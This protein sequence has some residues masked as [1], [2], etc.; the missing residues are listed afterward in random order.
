M[1]RNSL[2]PRLLP[3]GACPAYQY[4]FNASDERSQSVRTHCEELWTD[5][6]CYADENFCSEFPRRFHQRWFEMYLA[7]SLI[8]A[9]LSMNPPP[10]QRQGRGRPD[11]EITFCRRRV[12]IEAV[13]MTSGD[14]G[15]PDSVPRLESGKAQKVPIRQYVTRIRNSLDTKNQKFIKYIRDIIVACDDVLVIAINAGQIPFLY[16][17]LDECMMRS[18]YGAGDIIATLNLDSRKLV[19]IERQDMPR[20]RKTSGAEINVQPFVD[21]SMKHVSS[22]LA[23]SAHAF[24]RPSTLDGDF[25]LYPNLSSKNPWSRHSCPVAAEWIFSETDDGWRG[26]RA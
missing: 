12:W 4:V 6:S 3:R 8:R 24:N 22:V 10:A 14:A 17:E 23:S 16:R 11:I 2:F 19:S 18:L 9:G 5:F 25:V 13:C 15:L 7:V 26:N 20:I 1:K 21:G